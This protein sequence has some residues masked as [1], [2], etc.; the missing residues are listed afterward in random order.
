MINGRSKQTLSSRQPAA[1]RLSSIVESN[2]APDM[3]NTIIQLA[4]QINAGKVARILATI[5]VCLAVLGIT[6]EYIEELVGNSMTPL[7]ENVLWVF[8]LNHEMSIPA[9]YSA[10]L[11]LGCAGVLAAIALGKRHE[12]FARH[13]MGLAIIFLYLSIDEGAA[14]HET[15]TEPLQLA[16]EPTGMLYFAWVIVFV[17]LVLIFAL[18]YLPFLLHL[19]PRTRRLVVLAGMTYVGGAVIIE[20]ISASVWYANDGSNLFYSAIGTVEELFE[21]LGVIVFLYAMLGYVERVQ[22]GLNHQPVATQ[23]TLSVWSTTLVRSSSLLNRPALIVFFGGVNLILVQW[24]LVRELTTMLLGTELVVLLV[25]IAYFAGL[26][27]GYSL[28]GKIRRSWLPALGIATLILHLT[29]PIWFRLLVV[30]LDSIGAYGAAYLVLPLLT[31]FVVSA[32][33][34]VFLPLFADSGEGDLSRLYALELL[35]SAAGVG[36]LVLLGG[37]GMQTVFV[38]YSAGL[39]LILLALKVRARLVAILTVAAAAWLAVLPNANYWSNTLWYQ[40]VQG[41]PPGTITLFSGY[42]PYQKVDALESPSGARYLFLDGLEHFGTSGEGWINLILGRIPASL[43]QPANALVVGA[44]AMQTERMIAS[45]GGHVT[46]V[47]LDPLVVGVSLQHF[48]AFNQMD[49]LTNRSIVVDDAKHFFA[50]T[51]AQYDLIATDTP[52][53]YSIQ[54]ATLYSLPFYQSIHDHL[55]YDGVLAANLTSRF[56]PDDEVS[57]RIVAGLLMTFDDVIVVTPESIGWSFAYASDNLPFDRAAVELAL[58]QQGE[59]HYIIFDTPA[60]RALVGDAQP[61][62]LD[63]MDIALHV[64]ADWIEDRIR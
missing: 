26:S 22:V 29:L 48:T 4:L 61:I 8:G 11:L 31:P 19:P 42:S 53:A 41:L 40:A 32:F 16:L 13:W 34:S 5:A 12:R 58:R 57:R 36:V 60:V 2:S 1:T 24:V 15:L 49:V 20:G 63:T 44:G 59:I 54:T 10:A 45:F 25:S 43:A 7:L 52:A 62:T 17:P 50:N 9:W 28:A 55:A 14:L 18:A 23:P 37:L 56:A 64:S 47:E 21:M 33:Y 51:D 3:D 30:G 46:T 27:V 35:G 39:L 38:V 6:S